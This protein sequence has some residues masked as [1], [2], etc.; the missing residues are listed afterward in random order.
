MRKIRSVYVVPAHEV[1]DIEELLDVGADLTIL[2]L[3]DTVP[4]DQKAKAREV[5]K[6]ELH[7]RPA[8]IGDVVVGINDPYSFEGGKDVMMLL[9]GMY[10]PPVVIPGATA[11]SIVNV[12]NT[13]G[14]SVIPIIETAGGVLG[15]DAIRELF[16][17]RKFI[18]AVA[19]GVMT[20]C[21]EGFIPY[22]SPTA[23]HAATRVVMLANALGVQAIDSPFLSGN[24]ELLGKECAESQELGFTAKATF[25]Q[26][27]IEF[28]NNVFDVSMRCGMNGD[29]AKQVIEAAARSEEP[30]FYMGGN[31]VGPP[32]VAACK[33]MIGE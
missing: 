27:H 25:N 19:F 18:D 14:V 32:L 31:L 16:N 29:D 10:R 17:A 13:L 15:V 24:S 30:F 33:R 11:G 21:A 8:L 28:I 2:D 7:R 5:V 1:T 12:K 4:M 20:F 6:Q 22:T 3:G 9:D 23:L 26:D